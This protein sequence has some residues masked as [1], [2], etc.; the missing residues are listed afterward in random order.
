MYTERRFQHFR[1]HLQRQ[2]VATERN[3]GN[4][5]TARHNGTTERQNGNGRTATEWWK[6]G[7]MDLLRGWRNVDR[8]GDL[9]HVVTKVFCLEVRGKHQSKTQ[10]LERRRRRR[11]W[12][13]PTHGSYSPRHD[14][15]WS[16]ASRCCTAGTLPGQA[17]PRRDTSQSVIS[18]TVE[19]IRRP[20]IHSFV[21]LCP[22][23]PSHTFPGKLPTCC[24][25]VSDTVNYFDCQHVANKSATTV[26]VMEFG[27]R[28]DTTDTTDSCSRQLVTDL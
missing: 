20:F 23:I 25:L 3:N 27:K 28:H 18:A 15:G 6:R 21:R 11:C 19:R 4:G 1:S 5:T 2:R 26:V 24:G 10:S 16:T 7:I 17:V 22:K 9:L 14:R 12:R 13:R 8:K